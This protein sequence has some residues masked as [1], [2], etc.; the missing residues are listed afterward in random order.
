MP[1]EIEFWVEI[2]EDGKPQQ[3]AR[4]EGVE[5]WLEDQRRET[6]VNSEGCRLGPG[7]HS[8]YVLP[9]SYSWRGQSECTAG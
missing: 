5:R 6:E 2:E 9:G 1:G 3:P 4:K 8:S 7:N